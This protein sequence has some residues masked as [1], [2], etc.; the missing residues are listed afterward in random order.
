[1]PFKGKNHYA[2]SHTTKTFPT[3][4]NNSF[5][6]ST[7]LTIMGFQFSTLNVFHL[8]RCHLEGK[9]IMQQATCSFYL[10]LEVFN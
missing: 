10:N 7:I 8:Y 6:A 9:T 3:Y 4:L 1:V 5:L 2:T